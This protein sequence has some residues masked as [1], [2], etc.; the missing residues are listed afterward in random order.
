M[1]KSLA[2]HTSVNYQIQAPQPFANDVHENLLADLARISKQNYFSEY[3]LH[4][5]LSRTFKRLNDG[6][7]VWINRCYVC[8]IVSYSFE[9]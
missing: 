8:S 3:D 6:H 5:D 7:C 9:Y 1:N 2:F 4:I